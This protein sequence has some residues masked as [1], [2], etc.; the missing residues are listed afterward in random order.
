MSCPDAF[1]CLNLEVKNGK[2]YISS[3][4]VMPTWKVD[5]IDFE[6]DPNFLRIRQQ[7]N[8]G[9]WPNECNACKI[10]ENLGNQSR[11]LGSIKWNKNNLDSNKDYNNKILKIDYWTGNNCNLRCAICGPHYSIAWEKE[12]GI[13]KQKRITHTNQLWKDITVDELRWVHFNG[14][15]PLLVDEHWKLL[16]KIKNKN[17]VVLTYNTNGSVRPKQQLIDFWSQFKTVILDFSID[18]IEDRFEYQR[19]PARWKNVVENLFWF[20]ET[21]PV[22]VMFNIN[23][24]VGLLNHHNYVNLEKWFLKNF[25]K[26]RVN[27]PV[28]LLQQQTKG[29]LSVDIK[30]KAKVVDYLTILDNRRGTNWKTTF[31]ELVD[32]LLN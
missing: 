6:N 18:D 31:P 28:M 17:Q 30:D 21:M 1:N 4:C 7:W 23:T 22:N 10:E 15:E 19:Y 5:R 14:G 3:C 8:S 20:K 24:A 32:F 29:L 11:R 2:T 12:L 27:D 16:K 25:N 13:E 26:N 9:Q